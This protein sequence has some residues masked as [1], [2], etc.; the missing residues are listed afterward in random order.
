MIHNESARMTKKRQWLSMT[1]GA[2]DRRTGA[3]AAT[4]DAKSLE[5]RADA[6]LQSMRQGYYDRFLATGDTKL[7]AGGTARRRVPMTALSAYSSGKFALSQIR[8]GTELDFALK[9][10]GRYG[11]EYGSANDDEG[12]DDDS[13]E[14][15]DDDSEEGNSEEDSYDDD[16]DA[17][18]VA[19]RKRR[20][21]IKAKKRRRRERRSKK[22]G[23]EED[24]TSDDESDGGKLARYA[25]RSTRRREKKAR[26]RSEQRRIRDRARQLYGGSVENASRMLVGSDEDESDLDD[27]GG[28]GD[29]GETREER[30]LRRERAAY[31]KRYRNTFKG[32]LGTAPDGRSK[33]E[34]LIRFAID[35]QSSVGLFFRPTCSNPLRVRF[36]AS[37]T[38]TVTHVAQL[39]RALLPL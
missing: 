28:D 26:Q 10:A 16:D 13:E 2:V 32:V 8:T 37:R 20:A 18:A 39:A 4:S 5:A 35:A 30:R 14:D 25:N 23:G 1:S 21:R 19:R 3:K 7:A 22:D 36:P 33:L 27:A 6:L 31:A 17:D 11:D 34:A 15:S 12:D 29:D 9:T 38:I 24:D